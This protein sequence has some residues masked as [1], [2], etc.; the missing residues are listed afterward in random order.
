MVEVDVEDALG[1]P[2]RGDGALTCFVAVPG[3]APS[4]VVPRGGPETR[5]QEY[6]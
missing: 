4:T 6:F 5:N 2:L 1:Y 3:D